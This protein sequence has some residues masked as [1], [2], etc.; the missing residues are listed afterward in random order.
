MNT[1]QFLFLQSH[2]VTQLHNFLPELE[3]K[4]DIGQFRLVSA[5]AC[6]ECAIETFLDQTI[7]HLKFV[8]SK[9]ELAAQAHVLILRSVVLHFIGK[10]AI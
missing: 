10:R 5:R 8:L 3:H 1:L 7:F 4:L 9:V 2:Q 6:H